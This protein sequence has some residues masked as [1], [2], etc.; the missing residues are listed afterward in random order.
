M[1]LFTFAGFMIAADLALVSDSAYLRLS[2]V[3]QGFAGRI[4]SRARAPVEATSTTKLS[5]GAG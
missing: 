4:W 3:A 5:A 1:G 2:E